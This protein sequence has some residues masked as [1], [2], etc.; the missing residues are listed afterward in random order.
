MRHD[1][2]RLKRL[3][4]Q[5]DAVGATFLLSYA[6]NNEAKDLCRG[7]YSKTISLQ[8]NISGFAG[9]RGKALEM[10]VSNNPLTGRQE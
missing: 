8:R 4:R 9:A 3:L 10:I 7:W 6:K 1:L 5:I 2:E